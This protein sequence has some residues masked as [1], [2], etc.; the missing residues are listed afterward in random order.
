MNSNTTILL[1]AAAFTMIGF[2]LG[3]VTSP[4]PPMA[5]GHFEVLKHM[6]E[7]DMTALGA[8]GEVQVIVQSSKKEILRVTRC[9]PSPVVRCTWS[10]TAKTSKSR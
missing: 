10:K 3:R 7:G 6:S 5:A 9:L 4:K 1:V 8:S 2:I